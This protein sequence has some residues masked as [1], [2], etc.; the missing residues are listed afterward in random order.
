MTRVSKKNRAVELVVG[1]WR[2]CCCGVRAEQYGQVVKLGGERK[3]DSVRLN[4]IVSDRVR[5]MSK[6]G[7]YICTRTIA[8][9]RQH[10]DKE[11]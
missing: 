8:R 9:V 7:M 2:E 1:L 5:I 3:D 10:V 11:H 6:L 4:I